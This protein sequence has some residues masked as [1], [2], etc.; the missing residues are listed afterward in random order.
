MQPTWPQWMKKDTVA[1]YCDMSPRT[2]DRWVERGKLP[3]ASNDRWDRDDV[4][5]AF[6]KAGRRAADP[7]AILEG[8]QHG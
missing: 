2:V 5:K 7:D 6:G 8:L 1:R 4:D 3:P